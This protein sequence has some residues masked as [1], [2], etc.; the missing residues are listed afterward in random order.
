[1]SKIINVADHVKRYEDTELS[2]IN[3]LIDGL[4]EMKE[5]RTKEEIQIHEAA[6]E[7]LKNGEIPAPTPKATKPR[8]ER[9]KKTEK[10]TEE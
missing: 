2:L 3:A 6:L 10:P 4:T 8:G 5:R 1:M 7:K 9:K